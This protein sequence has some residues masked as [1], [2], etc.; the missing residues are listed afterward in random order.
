M[1]ASNKF[2]ASPAST[3]SNA[4]DPLP[5]GTTNS[6]TPSRILDT[7]TSNGGHDFP[8]GPEQTLALQVSG[9]GGVPPSDVTAVILNV[10]VTDATANSYLAVWPA[11]LARPTVSNINFHAGA[12]VPNLVEVALGAG[13]QVS[14]FNAA[15]NVDVIADVEGWIGDNTNSYGEQGL[16][17]G[18]PPARILD[19]R[20]SNG[21]HDFPLGPGQTLT[22]QVTGRGAAPS[23]EVAAVIMN[24]TVANPTA[25]SYLTVWPKGVPRPLASNLNFSAG[26]TIPN[27]VTVGVGSAGQVNFYNAA[28]SV[29]VIADVNGFFTAGGST[30]G[31]SAFVGLAPSRIIDSRTSSSCSPDPAPCPIGPGGEWVEAIGS[32]P[33]ALVM[34][35]T[36]A[37]STASSYLTVFPNPGAG[38]W[39]GSP[40][41]ASDLNFSAGETIANFTTVELDPSPESGFNAMVFYNAAGRVELIADV[42]GYYGPFVAASEIAGPVNLDK[43]FESRHSVTATTPLNS[44]TTHIVF[45]HA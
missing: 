14:F 18:L 21:G 12:A 42:D 8:L 6:V 1:I 38:E 45:R 35:V 44:K 2:A 19:T 36:V 27:R 17:E 39:G 10:T 7:R 4:V 24:V 31:G 41:E 5:G 22:L 3:P 16:F 32:G 9:R 40:P 28:G 33:T 15:G 26:E 29:N 13:G 23:N 37:G 25:S 43:R 11:G 34:N 20:T 30:Y